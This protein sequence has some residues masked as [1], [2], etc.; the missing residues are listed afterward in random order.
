MAALAGNPLSLR[1][2]KLKPGSTPAK[3]VG[4]VEAA[5]QNHGEPTM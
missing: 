4:V 2:L 5:A 3:N 1:Y